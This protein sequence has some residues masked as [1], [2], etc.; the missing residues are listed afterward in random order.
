MDDS[1]I[2]I[3]DETC[4]IEPVSDN[5]NLVKS[6]V[7]VPFWLHKYIFGAYEINYATPEQKRFYD[8]LKSRFLKGEY[9]DVKD[10]SNYIF[11]LL[12]E[13][14]NEYKEHKDIHLFER[15]IRLL[16]THYPVCRSYALSYLFKLIA[17][18]E[19]ERDPIFNEVASFVITAQQASVKAIQEM[20]SLSYQ[21]AVELMEQLEEAGVVGPFDDTPLRQVLMTSVFQIRPA[22]SD[23]TEARLIEEFPD[24][25]WTL[26]QRYAKQL[27]LTRKEKR[28]LDQVRISDS[29]F[30]RIEFF[31][32]TIIRLFLGS[33]EKMNAYYA[34]F[35]SSLSRQMHGLAD[36]IARKHYRYRLHSRN[37]NAFLQ[38]ASLEQYSAL[39]KI[40]ENE[41]RQYYGHKRKVQIPGYCNH[42]QIVD[43]QGENLF[44]RFRSLVVDGLAALPVLSEELEMELNAQNCTRWKEKF[45]KLTASVRDGNSFLAEILELGRL[46]RKNPSLD[47]IYFEASKAIAKT[48]KTTSLILYLHYL[49]TELKSEFFSYK[50]LSKTVR[51]SLFRDDDQMKEFEGII[52]R[53]IE[54]GDLAG[55]I[56]A[57][58]LFYQP[59][60]KRVHIN[61]GHIQQVQTH[62]A[63]T[64]RLLNKYLQ[65][66]VDEPE[67]T[68]LSISIP[69]VLNNHNSGYIVNLNEIQQS[70]LHLFEKNNFIIPQPDLMAFAKEKGYFVNQLIESINE[71]CYDELDD[72]LI[73]EDEACYLLNKDYYHRI[74]L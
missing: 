73:E 61:R 49:D 52:N 72:L 27:N 50:D 46:N 64:V 48:D 42:D 62:H 28:I 21:H 16:V 4:L 9:L 47:M 66:E 18:N 23:E 5:L 19:S 31:R 55:A 74:A 69:E 10:N 44:D 59:R 6:S 24:F 35:N 20:F 53:L 60:R 36:L 39:F 3:S 57:V 43:S 41:I 45:A 54:T 13:L 56:E 63:A 51:K 22:M 71:L 14:L 1:I 11:V 70:V 25:Y 34:M 40:C 17:E 65:D 29:S 68:E 30:N 8:E 2:D 38:S 33:V 12:F 32:L 58:K 26:S 15:Q 7:E 37:Y 67:E